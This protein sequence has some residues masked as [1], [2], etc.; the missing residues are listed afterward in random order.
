MSDDD[1]QAWARIV[2][3][4]V[5]LRRRAAGLTQAAL[6]AAVDSTVPSV[7]RLE[8]GRHL[9]TLERLLAVA[10]ALDVHPC[11]LLADVP[12]DVWTDGDPRD[13]VPGASAPKRARR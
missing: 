12:A 3:W 11:K 5:W 7:S 9:P 8:R 2:G 6:A 4:N 1:K 10:Q 13:W